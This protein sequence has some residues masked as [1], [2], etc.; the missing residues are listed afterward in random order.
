MESLHQPQ[1]SY[2]S[3]LR[4]PA[5]VLFGAFMFVCLPCWFQQVLFKVE[6]EPLPLNLHLFSFPLE[7][8]KLAFFQ[9]ICLPNV[10]LSACEA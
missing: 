2:W 8:V 4:K 6:V 5:F 9:G 10:T 7:V 3:G 1:G